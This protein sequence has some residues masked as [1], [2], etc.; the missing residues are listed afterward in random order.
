MSRAFIEADC[1]P[2]VALR[3][4]DGITLEIVRV[5]GHQAR[6]GI[7]APS[8]VRIVRRELLEREKPVADASATGLD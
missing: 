5:V 8:D 2:G 6:I 3:I 4:G 7:R 1:E